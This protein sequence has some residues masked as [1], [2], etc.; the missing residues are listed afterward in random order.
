MVE[1]GMG[2]KGGDQLQ[3]PP[4]SVLHLGRCSPHS[5]PRRSLVC[6]GK[7]DGAPPPSP[8]P[9]HPT[10]QALR[11]GK[12]P[13]LRSQP[14]HHSIHSAL[15]ERL[16]GDGGGVRER[17]I[18]GW[19]H[20]PPTRRSPA[21]PLWGA[22]AMT[23]LHPTHLT[24]L[25]FASLT[26][27]SL[28][29]ASFPFASLRVASLHFPSHGL[30]APAS[31][32]LP[33]K[34]AADLPELRR[35]HLHRLSISRAYSHLTHTH[36]P[37]EMPHRPST[38]P[39]LFAPP[40]AAFAPTLLTASPATTAPPASRTLPATSTTPPVSQL[41]LNQR[42]RASR[43]GR[44]SPRHSNIANPAL[45]RRSRAPHRRVCFQVPPNLPLSLTQ[46]D[47]WRGGVVCPFCGRTQ[48]YCRKTRPNQTP[49]GY[50]R[51]S[52]STTP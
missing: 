31:R 8:Y 16:E 33:S 45:L 4:L 50:P 2:G 25:H 23:A 17:K 27:V 1:G 10:H 52:C 11:R 41:L 6:G 19:P 18:R 40:L 28:R 26:F 42:V 47:N 24:R 5:T 13:L 51:R 43:P 36:T 49:P 34:R 32:T 29:F 22:H 14:F 35:P 30:A 20:P 3:R 48:R 39:L 21:L 9:H 37:N 46:L 15:A 12:A 38:F 7:W 44:H